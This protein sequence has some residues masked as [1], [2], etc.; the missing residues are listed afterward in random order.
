MKK[1]CLVQELINIK[2]KIYNFQNSNNKIKIDKVDK[3]KKIKQ[4]QKLNS[5][6]FNN[7]SIV[8]TKVRTRLYQVLAKISLR[9]IES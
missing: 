7:L 3:M 1:Y 8:R 4:I 2:L 6:D 5:K 9:L